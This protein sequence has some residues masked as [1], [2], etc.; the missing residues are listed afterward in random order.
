[1]DKG[2]IVI[3]VVI[4]TNKIIKRLTRLITLQEAATEGVL[5]KKMFLKIL[6]ISQETPVLESLFNKVVDLR[7]VSLLK[8]DS[9]TGV[10]LRSF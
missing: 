2:K 6:R 8:R 5:L 3:Q 7:P 1:M 10:F 4:T 9:N